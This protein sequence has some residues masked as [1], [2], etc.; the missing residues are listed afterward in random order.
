M[1]P[2]GTL[3]YRGILL[4]LQHFNWKWIGFIT[5][6][7]LILEWFTQNM[8]P[9][10]SRSGICFAM[11]E[12]LISIHY[13]TERGNFMDSIGKVFN[14]VVNSNINVSIFCGDTNTVA[15]LQWLLTIGMRLSIQQPKGKVWIWTI[16]MELKHTSGQTTWEIQIFHG[17]ISFSLPS[18]ELQGFQQFLQSRN[19][20][21][22]HGDDFIKDFWT[23]IFNGTF[24]DVFEGDVN[25]DMCTREEMLKSLPNDISPKTIQW[26]SYSMYN[27]VYT[28]AYALDAIYSSTVLKKVKQKSL[29][30][31][32]VM[33][34]TV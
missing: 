20:S 25:R 18:K 9:E 12:S 22:A 27:A 29:Q 28:M 11:M 34:S 13:D 14:K 30:A 6:G 2:K 4:L 26:Q 1:V 32:Q 8:L 15:L 10:F 23:C 17:S 5:A 3:Q 21:N 24:R 16:G 31:W 19:P 33:N 7:E